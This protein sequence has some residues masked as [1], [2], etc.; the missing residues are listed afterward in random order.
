MR[1]SFAV[2]VALALPAFA[3]APARVGFGPPPPSEQLAK[4]PQAKGAKGDQ[5]RHYYFAAAKQEMPYHLYVP[6]NYDPKVGAPL[7]VALH[8]YGGNQ[9]YFF[10]LVKDLPDL[11]EKYGVI[12]VAP[13]GY[14]TGGWYGAPLSIPGAMPRS[15]SQAN[16]PP[17]PPPPAIP[18]EEARH[19][20]ELSEAD[21]LNVV[22]MVRKEYK[23]DPSRIY[24]MGHSMGGFGAYFLGQ[25][26]ADIWAAVAPMS[27]T[28]PGV[29]YSLPRLAK[30]PM[31]I[32]AGSTETATAAAARA[33]VKEM[34]AMGMTADY[35][36][37]EGG[38]HMSM[39]PP[40]VPK[41]F[42]F[43]ATKKKGG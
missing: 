23:V 33:Q 16:A 30:T 13:M 26:H 40:T 9:D 32:S 31:L 1:V 42:A 35:A 37:V 2:A 34:K 39:I 43:F 4:Q 28:M 27:G 3:Q 22:A 5:Q 18:P 10:S 19:E 41:I 6:K 20:R 25:K 17:P 7:I 36:E 38:T 8:G 14:S 29:D 24:L 12:F 21:V 11:C 15:A